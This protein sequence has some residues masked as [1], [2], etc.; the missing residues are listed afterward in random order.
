[1]FYSIIFVLMKKP[2]LMLFGMVF[3]IVLYGCAQQSDMGFEV[4]DIFSQT[5]EVDEV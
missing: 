2:L 3:V 5:G 4:V 1:M